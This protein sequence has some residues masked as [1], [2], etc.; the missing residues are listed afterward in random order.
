MVPVAVTVVEILPFSTVV[1]SY[2]AFGF[3]PQAVKAN[4]KR[5]TDPPPALPVREGVKC[6]VKLKIFIMK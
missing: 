1:I 2:S 5:M 3:E 6:F 4:A